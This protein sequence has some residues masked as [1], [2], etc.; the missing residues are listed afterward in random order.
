[1]ALQYNK[2]TLV[3]RI[4][5]FGCLN[6][7][8]DPPGHDAYGPDVS[9]SG[10]DSETTLVGLWAIGTHGGVHKT[11]AEQHA[12][13]HLSPQRHLQLPDRGQ[14]K[15]DD[16]QIESHADAHGGILLALN[17]SAVSETGVPRCSKRSTLRHENNHESDGV[18][19]T[20]SHQDVRSHS[21][22]FHCENFAVE[23]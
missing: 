18:G 12:H 10:H 19:D 22:P 14:W 6:G 15:C 23:G 17:R 8:L 1:M 7:A 3:P 4:Q 16:A 9:V 5:A 13:A 20:E 2:V 11:K 21:L